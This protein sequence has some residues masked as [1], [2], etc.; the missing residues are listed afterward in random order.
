[1]N[2]SS[3]A[4][5]GLVRLPGLLRQRFVAYLREMWLSLRLDMAE[6]APAYRRL[7]R[8]GYGLALFLILALVVFDLV[9]A[10]LPRSD[11]LSSGYQRTLHLSVPVA[12]PPIYLLGWVIGWALVLTGAS[13]CPK[14]IFLPVAVYFVLAWL[15]G[16]GIAYSEGSTGFLFWLLPLLLL[17]ARAVSGRLSFWHNR[18]S[19]EF[20]LWACLLAA[21]PLTQGGGSTAQ[22]SS[23]YSSLAGVYIAGLP[24]WFWLGVD[25]AG[26][27]LQTA[28]GLLGSLRQALGARLERL[29]VP[30]AGLLTALALLLTFTDRTLWLMPVVLLALVLA[31]WGVARLRGRGPAQPW[32]FLLWMVFSAF[33]FAFFLDLTVKDVDT[34][35]NSIALRLAGLPPSAVFGLLLLYDIFTAGTRFAGVDGRWLPRRGR[36]LIYLGVIVL[37][38]AFTFL[39]LNVYDLERSAPHDLVVRNISFVT[40]LGFVVGGLWLLIARARRVWREPA[41]LHSTGEPHERTE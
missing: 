37:S 2:L 20:L 28:N 16:S 25:G 3:R 26:G 32:Y 10:D 8:L 34:D 30:M 17:A 39:A 29:A 12:A 35:V 22:A 21:F 9:G 11:F 38:A 14:R 27:V 33:V 7:A 5:V 24:F 18:P 31:V 15:S 40:Y 19:L 13:D 6:L 4:S 23:V 1:M 36:V 41:S